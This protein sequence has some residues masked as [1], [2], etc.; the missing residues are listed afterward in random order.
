LSDRIRSSQQR[1]AACHA[2]ST[3]RL[4]NEQWV[5][6]NDSVSKEDFT[7][8]SPASALSASRRCCRSSALSA[9][10]SSTRATGGT[11]FATL[12]IAKPGEAET[13]RRTP[14]SSLPEVAG[15]GIAFL[16]GHGQWLFFRPT[17][18]CTRSRTQSR[19]GFFRVSTP[20]HDS[21]RISAFN[22][23]PE[24]RDN[25]LGVGGFTR[26]PDYLDN[27]L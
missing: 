3:F 18:G 17:K 8:L 2:Q 20:R 9:A 27:A 15:V 16:P 1:A 25:A 7:L 5:F 6:Q 11:S 19:D 10:N 21:H 12:P 13:N 14:G 23:Q 24:K 22:F 26:R 4:S